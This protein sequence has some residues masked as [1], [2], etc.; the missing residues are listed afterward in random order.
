MQ[1]IQF[2][3]YAWKIATH[4]AM[5]YWIWILILGCMLGVGLISYWQQYH[6]GLVVTNLT[7]QVS[8]G[9]YIA[10][11]TFLVGVAAAAV[12]LVIP[13]YIFDRQDIKQVVV[14]GDSL[15]IAAV[16]M[17]MA[18]VFVDLGRPERFWHLI[19]GIGQLNFPNSL[20]AWDVVVLIGYLIL[21]GGIASYILYNYY[22][23][24]H[25]NLT[26]YLPFV[27]IA[28]FWA[29]GIHTVTAFLFSANSGR[30]FWHD[31]LL[32]PRFIASAFASGPAIMILVLKLIRQ[33]TPYPVH[34][35]IIDHLGI[36]IAI[37]LQ[38]VI[39]LLGAEIFTH[40]YAASAH[41]SSIQYLFFGLD[42]HIMLRS[43][44]W[45]AVALLLLAV[46][47]LMIHPLRA[48]SKLLNI[49][50][51]ATILGVWIEKGLGLVTPGFIPTPIGEILEYSPGLIEIGVSIGIW[52]LGLLIFT[53]LTKIAVTIECRAANLIPAPE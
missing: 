2:I 10:N 5:L 13:A 36:T 17:A 35:S 44:M 4:G 53:V 38:V 32:A 31:T 16:I 45:V 41:I 3:K 1:I 28:I 25:P 14:I 11:F 50:C 9:L 52:G 12:M 24:R 40:F 7:N 22:L 19:P 49:A 33:L 34:Q 47:I 39:F 48:N 27:V 46:F 51:V 23:G 15:A 29:I 42:Q 21:N 30:Q 18:F 26:W 6:Y 8:W 37:A 20:L 43:W